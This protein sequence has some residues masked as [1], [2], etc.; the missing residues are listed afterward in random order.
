MRSS[1]FLSFER[2]KCRT[3]TPSVHGGGTVRVKIN[4]ELLNPAGKE[5]VGLLHINGTRVY[6]PQDGQLT[7]GSAKGCDIRIIDQMIEDQ[8]ILITSK[9]KGFEI[10]NLSVDRRLA[11]KIEGIDDIAK[12]SMGEGNDLEITGSARLFLEL[13]GIGAGKQ[14]RLI[15]MKLE[16]TQRD[17][18]EAV[19]GILENK[20]PIREVIPTEALAKIDHPI[21]ADIAV[22]VD[23]KLVG[24]TFFSKAKTLDEVFDIYQR[25]H[26]KFRR[27]SE[28]SRLVGRL[29]GTVTVGGGIIFLVT[30][31]A[32]MAGIAALALISSLASVHAFVKNEDHLQAVSK[33]FAEFLRFANPTEIAGV[34]S[35]RSKKTR[36]LILVAI[37]EN[38][39]AKGKAVRA[40]LDV[41][42]GQAHQPP[43]LEPP[44]A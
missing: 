8:H 40:E 26:N 35:R 30:G 24:G 11:V 12:L 28:I 17:I 20:P 33:E 25:C 10:T 4:R 36:N 16:I 43:Q 19:Q 27:N 34:L 1:G 6:I 15:E 41:L 38:D 23:Q 44:K 32:G 3:V 2:I 22:A 29:G 31:V 39:R 21:V 13:S 5:I 42:L 7:I 9:E 37:N 14:K 18:T